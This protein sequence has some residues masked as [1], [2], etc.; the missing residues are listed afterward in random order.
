MTL[1]YSMMNVGASLSRHGFT[2]L[3]RLL[4]QRA[5]DALAA[6]FAHHEAANIP[7]SAQ[8]LFVHT[9]PPPDTPPF[10]N[11][12]LQWLNPHKRK[13]P[14]S[15]FPIATSLRPVIEELL[16]DTAVLFQDLLLDKGESQ[17][18]RFAWHQDYPFW[19]VD[20]PRGLVVW[21]P[22]DPVDEVAGSLVLAAGSHLSG[23]GPAIDLHSG[24]AQPGTTGKVADIDDYEHVC[25]KLDPGDAIVFHPLVWHAS[26][27]NRSGKRRRAWASSWLSAST[28]ICHARAPRHPLCK[29][30]PD[31]TPV[32]EWE[33][34]GI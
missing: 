15:T 3:P 18:S 28:R 11:L 22:I 10:D 1:D 30:I 33:R 24:N 17:R 14:L 5:L 16:G 2:I 4:D 25:R 9:P 23:I 29:I 12:M 31:G 26:A 34:F 8:V 21:V 6:S 13:A 27:P 19:P 32:S 20:K 7:R